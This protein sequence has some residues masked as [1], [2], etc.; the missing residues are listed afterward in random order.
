MLFSSILP[1][2]CLWIHV[3]LLCGLLRRSSQLFECSLWLLESFCFTV[4]PN[5]IATPSC[6]ADNGSIG[7]LPFLGSLPE[8]KDAF[9]KVAS[10]GS[11]SVPA[12]IIHQRG[13]TR[14]LSDTHVIRSTLVVFIPVT[15]RTS[16]CP[17]ATSISEAMEFIGLRGSWISDSDQHIRFDVLN[18]FSSGG[19][20]GTSG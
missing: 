12:R 13:N 17:L 2:R 7:R 10:T 8:P 6:S 4:Q 1:V 20:R 18:T 15:S 16:E 9:S 14:A 19:S 5:R 3:S 11:C